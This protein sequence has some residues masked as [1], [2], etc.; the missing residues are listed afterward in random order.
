MTRIAKR[1][2]LIRI[3]LGGYLLLAAVEGFVALYL[4]LRIPSDPKNVW[5][6]GLSRSRFVMS[7]GILA[8]ST[9]AFVMVWPI[10]R[11]GLLSRRIVNR[12]ER[13]LRRSWLYWLVLIIILVLVVLGSQLFYLSTRVLDTSTQAVMVRLSPLFFWVTALGIQTVLILPFLRFGFHWSSLEVDR[14]GLKVCAGLFGLLLL[15]WG[16]VAWT[17]I[18]LQ[19]D[20]VGWDDPGV[21]LLPL[22]VLLAWIA[23]VVVLSI[24]VAITPSMGRGTTETGSVPRERNLDIIISVILFVL[25]V[26]LWQSQPLV[27]DFFAPLPRH[28]N[29][30]LYPYS[31]AANHDVIA[32][33]LLVGE[34]YPGISRKPLYA[35][36]LFIY[37]LI[38]GQ[39]YRA[40]VALQVVLLATFPVI[41]FW[42]T[43]NLHHRASA[44]ILA[45]LIILRERNAIALSG[46][47]RV[48]HSKL[49]MAGL[50]AA[51]GVTLLALIMIQWMRT[52]GK[53]RYHPVL[54]GG[55]LGFLLLI[56]PQ[57]VILVPMILVL[58][59]ARYWRKTSRWLVA[60]SL[61][62][63]GLCLS[64]LPWML[65]S[66]NM[67]GR[68]ILNDPNQTAFLTQQ[69]NLSPGE[70]QLTRAPGESLGDFEQ[71]VKSEI[72]DYILENPGDVAG[73]VSA[74][75]VHNLVEN[76]LPLPHTPWA[77][78]RFD[79]DLFPQWRDHFDRLW[80]D[81]C[82]LNAYV[83]SLSIWD[84]WD[85]R[86]TPVS[87]GATMI[88]LALI[89]IGIA[90]TWRFNRTA[91]WVP[92]MINIAYNISTAI[93]RY[94]GWRLIIPA[95][96]V[97]LLFFSIGIGQL[98][99]WFAR[100]FG[101]TYA[102]SLKLLFSH[103]LSKDHGVGRSGW[104]NYP[105][106]TRTGL[107]IAMGILVIAVGML[108]PE[109]LAEP[110]Y[111]LVTKSW[112]VDE[113]RSGNIMAGTEIADS[114]LMT[115]YLQ[116]E[117]STVLNGRALYPRYFHAGEGETAHGWPAYAQRD[118]ERLGFYIVGPVNA[119]V[120][121]S[122]ISPSVEFPNASEVIVIGCQMEDY[123]DA[124]AVIFV[125]P[126]SRTIFR[127]PY[128]DAPCM[129]EIES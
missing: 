78:Y 110:K 36:S 28:P 40:I 86:L 127:A 98:S 62:L 106:F 73:F 25:A 72:V 97:V 9:A 82:W 51:V 55:V 29:Y 1:D 101:R 41:L 59:I 30:E 100:Y 27:S 94:S 126:K 6:L 81:C 15:I 48:S 49:M 60:G 18:G 128:S 4:L 112:A 52:P 68:F 77:S 88:N 8:L 111:K 65:R 16:V 23:G 129:P 91:V 46:I 39:D 114:Q 95:D 96:W 22:Q 71:R 63:V 11:N 108:L 61:M 17:G 83:E 66:W 102:L 58:M 12:A 118:F 105:L 116:S 103:T 121:L 57:V 117:N 14:K 24:S 42:I 124:L 2:V 20:L 10:W 79:S 13:I 45:I 89:A 67:T 84:G 19:P 38:S 43:K 120:V 33:N 56:R 44:V 47:I 37:H 70:G 80:I 109:M 125:E 64:L 5:I 122:Q 87:I 99:I 113:I 53:N 107:G 69:Y 92:I 26:W 93:G 119:N 76:V 104:R 50:P 54:A 74:H 34:G 32:Q 123:I 35:F 85:G 75:F 21:P 3:A 7:A 31:D 90:S 115:D